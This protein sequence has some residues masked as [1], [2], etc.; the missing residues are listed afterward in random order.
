LLPVACIPLLGPAVG[1]ALGPATPPVFS[2]PPSSASCQ[3]SRCPTP[4]AIACEAGGVPHP[5]AVAPAGTH[6]LPL[7]QPLY[8]RRAPWNPRVSRAFPTRT[9]DGHGAACGP[10]SPTRLTRH[11]QERGDDR[12]FAPGATPA[13][14]LHRKAVC[15]SRPRRVRSCESIRRRKPGLHEG[16]MMIA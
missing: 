9:A 2:L 12:T 5:M 8:P 16:Q 6:P 14:R 10:V 4:P 11:G 7:Q 15:A 1:P 13:Q 3:D